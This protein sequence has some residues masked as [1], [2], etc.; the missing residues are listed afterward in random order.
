MC[1]TQLRERSVAKRNSPKARQRAHH[2]SQY[3]CRDCA[4]AYDH[5]SP[6]AVDGR[7]ILCRCKHNKHGGAFLDF[8]SAPACQYFSIKDKN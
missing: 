7:D 6:S 5:Q 8:L 4:L 2:D 1:L 3:C